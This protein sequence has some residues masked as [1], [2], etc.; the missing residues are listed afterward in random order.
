MIPLAIFFIGIMA[1][2]RYNRKAMLKLSVEEKARLL[3][4]SSGFALWRLLPVIV[5]ILGFS[6]FMYWKPSST[7]I[8]IGL[9]IY[10]A[11]LLLV[12]ITSNLIIQRKYRQLGFPDFYV[13][14]TMIGSLTTIVLLIGYLS[15]IAFPI[16]KI[17]G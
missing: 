12:S 5:L 17:Q 3:D 2:Q 15:W 16:M 11:L 9:L 14:T 8:R 4:Y 13:R 1:V 7:H 10:F 6:G